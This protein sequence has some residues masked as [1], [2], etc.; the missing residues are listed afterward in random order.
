MST[1][2]HH[3]KKGKNLMKD[4]R[5][6]SAWKE[7]CAERGAKTSRSVDLVIIPRAIKRRRIVR[8]EGK[9]ADKRDEVGNSLNR[10]TR[11]EAS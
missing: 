5:V 7:K 8:F 4:M 1:C 3:V 11:E 10:E 6:T 9:G 2:N